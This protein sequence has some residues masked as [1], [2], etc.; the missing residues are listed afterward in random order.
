LITGTGMAS[1]GARRCRLSRRSSACAKFIIVVDH[2]ARARPWLASA[3]N[4][5]RVGV[6]RGLLA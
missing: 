6:V 4:E 5:P 1:T 2:P 3:A